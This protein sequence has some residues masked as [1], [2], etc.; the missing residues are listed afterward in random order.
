M[1]YAEIIA[2][3]QETDLPFAYD[4]FAEGESPD[5]PF[6][7][8]L[9]PGSDNFSADGVV[10]QKI[11]QLRFELYT[12]Y[13]QPGVEAAFETVLSQHDLYYEKTEIW[14]AEERL[15]EITYELEVLDNG[16]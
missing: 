13:K 2:M 16:Q 15:Y 8:F 7:V 14:I 10:Y 5:P 11:T 4:H 3:L 12:D 1:T 9:F 6:L